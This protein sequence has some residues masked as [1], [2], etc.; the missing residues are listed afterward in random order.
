MK[1]F[2]QTIITIGLAFSAVSLV[3]CGNDNGGSSGRT[4]VT[5]KYTI[6]FSEGTRCKTPVRSY[7]N[8]RDF[9]RA[10]V[11]DAI[12]N[13]CARIEREREYTRQ[14]CQTLTG[15][16]SSATQTVNN[17]NNTTII[18]N[19]TTSTNSYP[20][21]MS[22]GPLE[23]EV[24]G[25]DQY[26][27]ETVKSGY[28]QYT[29][30]VPW[31]DKGKQRLM[32]IVGSVTSVST[33][34]FLF[35]DTYWQS[36]EAVCTSKEVG[37]KNKSEFCSVLQQDAKFGGCAQAERQ[38][39]F[40]MYCSGN[41]NPTNDQFAFNINGRTQTFSDRAKYCDALDDLS[42]ENDIADALYLRDCN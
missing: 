14:D 28:S 6:N 1:K 40:E 25:G 3:A 32:N 26:K 2:K 34:E 15:T 21:T 36:T 5:K 23:I 17:N 16:I 31:S 41:F 22:I 18:G 27:Y 9:C 19:T 7:T 24:P 4:S 20:M 12:N 38:S 10:L 33:G 42:I 30:F 39:I 8:K 13:S 11:N 29:R 35:L 37:Y